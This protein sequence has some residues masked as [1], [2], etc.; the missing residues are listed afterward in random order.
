MYWISADDL[1]MINTS[2]MLGTLG[3]FHFFHHE[4]DYYANWNYH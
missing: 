3:L 4:E 2:Y 1:T